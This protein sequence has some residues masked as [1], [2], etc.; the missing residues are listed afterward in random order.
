MKKLILLSALL[1][2][3]CSSDD[4]SDSDS[5]SNIGNGPLVLSITTINPDNGPSV[6][7]DTYT[8]DGNKL[9]SVTQ[10]GNAPYP[11]NTIHTNYIVYANDRV[12]RIDRYTSNDSEAPTL[13][14]EINFSYDSQGRVI[15]MINTLALETVTYTIS[16]ASNGSAT[17]TLEEESEVFNPST[18]TFNIHFDNNDNIDEIIG[19][20]DYA[21]GIADGNYDEI[22]INYEY[23]NYNSPFKNVV[24]LNWMLLFSGKLWSSEP[25]PYYFNNNSVSQVVSSSAGVLGSV[26]AYYD[27][28]QD[29]YP[30][31]IVVQVSTNGYESTTE[32]QYSN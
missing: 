18:S 24:G 19:T 10:S 26:N 20:G 17:L 6:T 11:Y 32:I 13:T 5:N 3:A 7:T 29:G 15:S 31:Q 16:Y 8:Y 22:T 2:F 9:K 27:Y 21:D 30:R 14:S 12:S 4:S 28:N 23:D 1:I 25:S